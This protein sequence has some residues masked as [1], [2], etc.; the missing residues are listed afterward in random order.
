MKK[1]I[2]VLGLGDAIVDLFFIVD[3]SDLQRMNLTKGSMMLIEA[4]E[5][6][7]MASAAEPVAKISGGSVAN[8]MVCVAYLGG[9]SKFIGKTGKDEVGE[10]FVK[11]MRDAGVACDTKSAETGP[12]TGRCNIYVTPDAERTMCVYPGANAM[13]SIDDVDMDGVERSKVVL[14]EGYL[15]DFPSAHELIRETVNLASKFG[16][17]VALSLSDMLLVD[18]HRES[19]QEIVGQG[20]VDILLANELEVQQLYQTEG[21]EQ[22]LATLQGK[23]KTLIVTRSEQGSV[24]VSQEEKFIKDA[25]AVP[26]LVDTTG[27]GDAYAGGFLYAYTSGKSIS[28]CMDAATVAASRVIGHIGARIDVKLSTS[29]L[30]G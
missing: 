10:V 28:E 19:F 17:E 30:L 26:E 16:T 25:L 13:L 4:D 18:R 27:A 6:A 24:A 21:L 1:D 29:D 5:A 12:M 8:S 14:I 7:K 23:V 15:W 2:D 3:D 9:C 20:G 11:D 22:S